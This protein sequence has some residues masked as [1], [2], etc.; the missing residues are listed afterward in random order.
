MSMQDID[1]ETIKQ[2]TLSF[3]TQF[4][5]T[6]SVPETDEPA[7]I[8]NPNAAK[9]DENNLEDENN[10]ESELSE[11]PV[12]DPDLF[13]SIFL[14]VLS[15]YELKDLQEDSF[16]PVEL[17]YELYEQIRPLLRI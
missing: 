7:V 1:R 15:K 12:V 10:F 13:M 2:Q 16:K 9:P 14:V 6:L 3:L 4:S 8:E 5:D 11:I 17:T